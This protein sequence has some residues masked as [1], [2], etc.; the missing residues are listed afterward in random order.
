[1]DDNVD[2]ANMLAMLLKALGHEAVV[3][4]A[5]LRALELAR[6][7]RAQP[8][9]AHSV[10]IAVSGYGQDEDRKN[11]PRSGYDQRIWV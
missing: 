4:H 8:E 3:E 1:M 5:S 11:A 6:R 9:T 10:L 2:A 7:L